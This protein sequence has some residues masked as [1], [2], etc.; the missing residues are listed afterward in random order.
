MT[1]KDFHSGGSGAKP[2]LQGEWAGPPYNLLMG[3]AFFQNPSSSSIEG[4]ASKPLRVIYSFLRD[5]L[6]G[7]RRAM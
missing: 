2:P 1:A 4:M 7:N 3:E 5:D 6:V